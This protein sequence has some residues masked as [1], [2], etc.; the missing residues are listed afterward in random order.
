L[1]FRLR[2]CGSHWEEQGGA[3]QQEGTAVHLIFR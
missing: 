1:W 2:Q 3:A